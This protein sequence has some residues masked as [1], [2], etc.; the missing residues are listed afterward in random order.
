[1]D[2][3]RAASKPAQRLGFSDH[4]ITERA[5]VDNAAAGEINDARGDDLPVVGGT[6]DVEGCVQARS[7]AADMALMASGSNTA[8]SWRYWRIGMACSC[9]IGRELHGRPCRHGLPSV[10]RLQS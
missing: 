8:L 2:F 6:V 4:A 10:A 1:M 9:G 7:R 3:R 5:G